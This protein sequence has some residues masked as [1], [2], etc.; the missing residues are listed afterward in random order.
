MTRLRPKAKKNTDITKPTEVLRLI[1]SW[2]YYLAWSQQAA[3]DGFA[4]NRIDEVISWMVAFE[5][6]NKQHKSQF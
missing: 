5:D 2:R 4:N 1:A 3:K 6:K